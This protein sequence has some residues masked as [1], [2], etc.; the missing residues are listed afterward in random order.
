MFEK[1]IENLIALYPE[2]FFPDQGFTLVGQQII[3]GKCRADLIFKDKHKR[4]IIIE[5]KRGILGREASGQIIEYYG[6]LKQENPN[7]VVELIL[8][9][10]TIPAERK[11]FLERVGIECKELGLALIPNLAREKGY[12]FLDE[13]KEEVIVHDPLLNEVSR[14]ELNSSFVGSVWIFQTNPTRY[15]ILN[16][17]A[18]LKQLGWSVNQHKDKIK[19]GDIALIWMSG[20]NAGIYAISQVISDPEVRFGLPEEDKYCFDKSLLSNIK[21][22][23]VILK[24]NKN[25]SNAPLFKNELKNFPNL[26]N[27]SILNHWRGT[28]FRV[29]KEEW[30]IIKDEINETYR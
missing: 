14:I 19:K 18:E 23:M 24:I 16:A 22:N 9:A 30:S 2:R 10:N 28:N 11:M 13:S 5:V 4:T 8:C 27:L 26:K 20:E 12:H 7:E 3:L 6:L 29:T 15:N 17:L 1:D 21:G 25:M